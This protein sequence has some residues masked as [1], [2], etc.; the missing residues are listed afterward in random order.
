MS[1]AAVLLHVS[2][3]LDARRRPTRMTPTPGGVPGGA[4]YTDDD[5]V[6]PVVPRTGERFR[7]RPP[8]LPREPVLLR[9]ATLAGRAELADELFR[10]PSPLAAARLAD[11]CLADSDELTRMAAAA[12]HFRVSVDPKPSIDTLAEGTKSGDELVR[13]VAA[14]ALARVFPRHPAL[15]RLRQPGRAP[16][17]EARTRTTMLIHGTWARANE[18]WQPG[19][20]FHAFLGPWRSDLYG[21]TDRFEWTGGYSDNARSDAASQLVDWIEDHDDDGLSLITHSHGGNVAFLASW[22]GPRIGD[23]VVLSCPVWDDYVPN[24]GQ[25][26]KLV[27]VR[28]KWDLVIL[29]DGGGQKFEDP[30]ITEIVLPVWFN[31]SAT[32]YP[33]VWTANNIA[34]R[35]DAA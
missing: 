23:L 35:I 31:H 7:L 12:L 20:T 34:A 3:Q 1:R 26:G 32:H 25:V 5:F 24:F 13:E 19:G 18:W 27:S 6:V 17:G 8:E 2:S 16:E 29:A 33:D 28:V 30:G 4:E 11:L 15:D 14:T 22:G 9:D 21:A 10:N